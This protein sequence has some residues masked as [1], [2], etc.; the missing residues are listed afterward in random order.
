[1]NPNVVYQEW[2]RASYLDEQTKQELLLIQ[3]DSNEI[4]DRFCRHL[5]FG[6]G[7]VRGILGAGRNRINRYTIRRITRGLIASLEPPSSVEKKRGV[8]IAYDNRHQSHELAIETANTLLSHGIVAY[9][10]PSECPTPLL[11]FAIRELKTLAGVVITASHNPP[12][13]NGYKIYGSDGGQI[14]PQRAQKISYYLDNISEIPDHLEPPNCPHSDIQWLDNTIEDQYIAQLQ[15][16]LLHPDVLSRSSLRVIYTPLHGVGG[17]LVQK[18][19]IAAGYS[20]YLIVPEQAEPDPEF[21]TVSSPNPEDPT[22]FTLAISL[23]K[24]ENADLLIATDPDCDRAGIAVKQ[25]NGDYGFLTGNQTGALLLH[26]LL[27]TNK[28]HHLLQKGVM[29]QTVVSSPL[30]EKIALSHGLEVRK[31]L[32]GFKYIGEQIELI[33][34]RGEKKF[35]FGYEESF[36]YLAGTFVRDKDGVMATLLLTEMAA[37]YHEQQ[38]TLIDVLEEIYNQY[39]F[40]AESLQTFTLKG[41]IGREKMQTI[42]ASLR[43]KPPHTI[44]SIPICKMVDYERQIE[45]FIGKISSLPYPKENSLQFILQDDSWFCVRPSGTEPKMKIYFSTQGQTKEDCQRKLAVLQEEVVSLIKRGIDSTL[46]N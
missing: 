14:T 31:T 26:Y 18:T 19:Y 20:N 2:L 7:G 21:R 30:G 11:S 35:V 15:E 22:A 28:Q 9:L 6:T 12:D 17:E 39:G 41:E 37:Y 40:F 3:G 34:Q 44:G 36:G 10:F 1:M 4:S 16:L 29:I 38:K 23:G 25:S 8:V 33:E 5:E 43:E 45:T 46:I 27:T 24:K 13:Y 42:M 32:T